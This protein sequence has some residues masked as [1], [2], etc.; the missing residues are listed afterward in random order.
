MHPGRKILNMRHDDNVSQLELAQASNITPSAL[1]KI[2]AGINA[3]RAHI[4]WRIAKYLGVSI[5]YL[6]DEKL[7][8][9]YQGYTYKDKVAKK[10]QDPKDI[11]R[12]NITREEKAFLEALTE[13]NPIARDIS[14]SIPE[15]P[16]EVLRV[17]HFLVYNCANTSRTA[18]LSKMS[19]M[20]AEGETP[21][22]HSSLDYTKTPP[23][24]NKQKRSKSGTGKSGAGKS[25]S[26]KSA[27]KKSESSSKKS[28]K[29][30]KSKKK[31]KK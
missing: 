7:P 26:K 2:E 8:Y 25:S 17:M 21:P 18:L 4:L 11:V 13:C 22:L 16:I 9:P 14:L 29:K 3:P 30:K 31:K 23:P 1:S 27:Q 20:I 12:A 19:E 24:K 5:E 10:N 15:M 28:T 6:L